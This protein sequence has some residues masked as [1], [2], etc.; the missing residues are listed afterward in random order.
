MKGS[1]VGIVAGSYLVLAGIC[2]A[3][4][5]GIRVYDTGNSEFAGML[6]FVAT[7]PASILI[8]VIAKRV[9]AINVGDSNTAFVVILGLA[10]ALNAFLVY[11]GLAYLQRTGQPRT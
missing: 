7:L 10:A 11:I 1:R 6:S 2:I 5:L 9:F 3:Y 4:E 8:D